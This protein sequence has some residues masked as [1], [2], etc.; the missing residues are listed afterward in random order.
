MMD[1]RKK[2]LDIFIRFQNPWIYVHIS[3]HSPNKNTLPNFGNLTNSINAT[4]AEIRVDARYSTLNHDQFRSVCTCGMAQNL[5]IE[6]PFKADMYLMQSSMCIRA[7]VTISFRHC[8]AFSEFSSCFKSY[9]HCSKIKR[10]T[11]RKLKT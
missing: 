7:S 6:R 3:V 5:N 8:T 11:H 1:I 9:R 2:I 10:Y 4:T